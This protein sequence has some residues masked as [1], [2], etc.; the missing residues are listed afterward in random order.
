MFGYA[1][2]GTNLPHNLVGLDPCQ[3]YRVPLCRVSARQPVCLLR[4][5]SLGAARPCSWYAIHLHDRVVQV[6]E[7]FILE[8]GAT[9]GWHL[10]LEVH[11]IRL[12]ASRD[13]PRDEVWLDLMAPHRYHLVV[14]V[15]HGH[16]RSHEHK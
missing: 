5:T 11:R 14:D 15:T 3:K 8:A 6:L 1:H 16:K 2:G 12:G 7:E 10:R 13:R 4:T 9:K